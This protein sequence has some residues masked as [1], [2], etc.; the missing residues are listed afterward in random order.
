MENP[1]HGDKKKMKLCPLKAAS[2]R[3]LKN[4]KHSVSI[5]LSCSGF[6]FYEHFNRQFTYAVFYVQNRNVFE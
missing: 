3:R 4:Y 2:Y 6:P 5:G 1:T